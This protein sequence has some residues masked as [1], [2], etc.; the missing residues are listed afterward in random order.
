[1]SQD[2]SSQVEKSS[3]LSKVV[4]NWNWLS[5][6][7]RILQRN[8]SWLTTSKN[9]R[10][11]IWEK[12]DLNDTWTNLVCQK[13]KCSISKPN[14]PSLS[15]SQLLSCLNDRT[16]FE[17]RTLPV[18]YLKLSLCLVFYVEIDLLMQYSSRFGLGRLSN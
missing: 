7:F 18:S 13:T 5:S 9:L 17:I 16:M 1:M 15:I 6:E 10:I 12:E 14:R 8:S 3:H 11:K 2:E 4:K